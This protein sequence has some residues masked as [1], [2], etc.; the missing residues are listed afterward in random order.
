MRIRLW[1]PLLAGWALAINQF[2]TSRDA[3]ARG[4]LAFGHL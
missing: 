1:I 3:D 4:N 2:F